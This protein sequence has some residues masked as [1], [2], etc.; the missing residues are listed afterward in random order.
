MMNFN[1]MNPYPFIYHFR[2]PQ[3]VCFSI[4]KGE[5]KAIVVDCGY[6]IFNIRELVESY[7]DTPYIVICTH[8]HMDHSS[9]AYLFDEVYIPRLDEQLYIKHNGI[10]KRTK[11]IESAKKFI[12]ESCFKCS[13]DDVYIKACA[14]KDAMNSFPNY[15]DKISTARKF[16]FISAAG[17]I[18]SA[19]VS[20]N[21]KRFV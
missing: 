11:N 13:F 8:G 5:S 6:G 20:G 19:K 15:I 1:V 10:E 7:I 9:G 4:I 18:F 12:F 3:G 17:E 14:I 21:L 2:D 16:S